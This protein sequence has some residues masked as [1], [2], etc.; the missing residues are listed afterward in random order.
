MPDARTSLPDAV[1]SERFASST[2]A[3]ELGS[4]L[5]AA[6]AKITRRWLERIAARVAVPP[7]R[8]FPTDELLDHMPLLI[9]GI[10]A[11]VAKPADAIPA[12]SVVIHRARELGE[13]RHAQGFGE[14]EILKEFEIL[15]SILFSFL[16][17]EALRLHPTPSP[18]QIIDCATRLFQA[19][20]LVQQAT[21]ARFLELARAKV[22]EREARLRTFHRALTHEMRNRLGA[23]LGAGQILQLHDLDPAER[24]TLANVIVRNADSMRLILENLLELTRLDEDSRQQRHVML[25]AALFEVVR[26]LRDMAAS[27]TVRVEIVDDIPDVEVN[28]AAVELCVVNLVANSIKYSNPA[29]RDRWVRI[30]A[31]WANDGFASESRVTITVE[32]NGI[33]IPPAAMPRLFERFFR[34]HTAGERHIEGTGLGLSLVRET[35]E[36]V[37]GKAWV[38]EAEVGARFRIAIPA[39]RAADSAAFSSE[40]P[41]HQ[42]R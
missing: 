8:V 35:I 14:Y 12:D 17:D 34:A 13:L 33:G 36:A 41:S 27:E 28:A 2:I 25:G 23:T 10:A 7:M 20:T 31:G 11:Y 37:G 39:R 15:G 42:A 19:V 5:S 4:A 21:T 38:E 22:S 1:Q 18:S 3:I 16:G 6:R 9:D 40:T 29:E 30:T 24:D 26:Q 32:D